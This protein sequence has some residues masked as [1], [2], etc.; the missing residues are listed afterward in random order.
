MSEL[1]TSR[2]TTSRPIIIDNSKG[3]NSLS[4]FNTPSS[5]FLGT[6]YLSV[7]RASLASSYGS[8]YEEE[9]PLEKLEKSGIGL[10]D[11]EQAQ[12]PTKSRT[13]DHKSTDSMQKSLQRHQ[14][15]PSNL[16]VEQSDNRRSITPSS[17]NTRFKPISQAN[18]VAGKPPSLPKSRNQ[19]TKDLTKHRRPS[20][21]TTPKPKKIGSEASFSSLNKFNFQLSMSSIPLEY[22]NTDELIETREVTSGSTQG[23]LYSLCK[24]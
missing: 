17:L 5:S 8:T 2:G 20:K 6:S 1:S 10:E 4:A 9:D 24:S 18:V 11:D 7:A 16:Y 23:K 21:P 14:T 13:L 22:P 12:L 3:A 15:A 19:S